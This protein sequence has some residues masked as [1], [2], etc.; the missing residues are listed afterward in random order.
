MDPVGTE[1]DESMS[2]T[3]AFQ[4]QLPMVGQPFLSAA[5]PGQNVFMSS[6]SQDRAL[7]APPVEDHIMNR[8]GV[9]FV[10]QQTKPWHTWK[11]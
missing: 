6:S 11:F 9:R 1:N 2:E 4:E 10:G 7:T 5:R 8:H 3:C